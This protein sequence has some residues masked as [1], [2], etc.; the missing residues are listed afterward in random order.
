MLMQTIMQIFMFHSSVHNKVYVN[1]TTYSCTEIST[2]EII[3]VLVPSEPS[4][5]RNINCYHMNEQLYTI[6]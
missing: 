2:T 5:K 6:C 3:F 4:F 1:I